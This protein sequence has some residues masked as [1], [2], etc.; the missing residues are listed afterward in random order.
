MYDAD[1]G[2]W[3]VYDTSP[4]CNEWSYAV[5]N[6]WMAHKLLKMGTGKVLTNG[7]FLIVKSADEMSFHR[8]VVDSS[9]CREL[10]D[11]DYCVGVD[12]SD[13]DLGM[14]GGIEKLYSARYR[15]INV[16]EVGGSYS[17]VLVNGTWYLQIVGD[18]MAA[19]PSPVPEQPVYACIVATVAAMIVVMGLLATRKR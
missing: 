18:P 10:Y 16:K 8:T 6:V 9:T 13:V 17:L 3:I 5:L 2:T 1:S 19:P 15:A 12:G 11:A 7:S 4:H 14:A